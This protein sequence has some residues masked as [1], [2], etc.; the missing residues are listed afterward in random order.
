MEPKAKIH[1]VSLGVMVF[2]GFCA[3]GA[4]FP[5]KTTLATS[6]RPFSG[7]MIEK[8]AD[9]GQL[10][11]AFEPNQG[12]TDPQVQ[13]LA[14]GRGYSLFLTS[15]EAVLE[16]NPSHP[17]PSFPAFF[18][19]GSKGFKP[20]ASLFSTTR[21]GSPTVLRMKLEGAQAQNLF[22]STESLPGTSNYFIGKDPSRWHRNIPQYGKVQASGVYPGVDLV[23]YGNQGHLEYDFVVKPGGDPK[24]IHLQYEGAKSSRVNAQGDLELDTNQGTLLFR[25]PAMYQESQGQR[26]TVEG[27]YHLDGNGRLGFDVKGYDATQPLVIDPVLDYST[28]WGGSG[29]DQGVAIALDSS[30]NAYITG[31]T[32]SPDFPTVNA[33]QGA[34][35]GTEN[36]F[37]AEINPS[38]TAMLYSTYL[39][40]NGYDSGNGIG[41]DSAGNA[42][43]TGYTSSTNFPLSNPL[44]P[45]LAGSY[46]VFVAE[47][48]T[49]GAG[50]AYSTYIGGS[51]M[52][53]GFGLAIDGSDDAYVVGQTSS[54]NFPTQ[55]PIQPTLTAGANAF[56]LK[57]NPTG[58]ALAYSTYLGG[59]T[60]E[61]GTAI[62]VDSAGNAY[63][64][65]DTASTDFPTQNP[66]QATL[67][68]NLN[69]FITE[70]NAS[71]T[72]LVYSTYLGG[73]NTDFSQGIA[74]D[75][76][77]N[78]YISGTTNSTNFPLQNPIQPA[79]SNTNDN[80]F[81][82]EIGA[83]GTSLVY[84]TYLGGGGNA[85][86]YGDYA[87]F[88][89]GSGAYVGNTIA[90][91]NQGYAYV[92][93]ATGSPD[94]PIVN[95]PQATNNSPYATAFV[96]QINLNGAGLIYST[97]L[98]G[99]TFESGYGIATDNNGNAYVV[100]QTGS[101]DFP[102]T[103][104]PPQSAL[105][106]TANAFIAE[107][108]DPLPPTPTLTPTSTPTFTPSDTPTITPT[109][110]PTATPTL[111]PTGTATSTFTVTP[112]L[113][114]TMTFTPT[115]TITSTATATP[116]ATPF[117]VTV[118]VGDPY[119]NPI[120]GSGLLQIPLTVPTG[121]VAHWT[122]YTAGFRKVYENSRPVSGNYDKL[123]WDLRDTWGTTVAN[124]LYYIRIQVSGLTAGSRTVKVLVIR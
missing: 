114:A 49:G 121:S 85:N 80:V 110:T 68:G 84:S 100:G 92:T 58:S 3:L 97:F 99:S 55:N 67:G 90:V 94:F 39:G 107:I 21:S 25:A 93:G 26:K 95:A 47:I 73:S 54:P 122:V 36:A 105:A 42:F 65:G 123:S 52:D 74:V 28:Y 9:Y 62:A 33:G 18:S 46:N 5:K 69:P 87:G 43:I 2:L 70:I 60:Y 31:N 116:T 22:Q 51:G 103:V 75:P 113:T 56:V 115:P 32:Q 71:G 96:A 48:T 104:T 35:A 6:H 119:P 4:G 102:V 111:T 57:L 40:G 8:R 120:S 79:L 16:L 34:L 44:Q 89:G 78:A 15:Q 14:H 124:G 77:S 81:V 7:R 59:S 88:E 98:G 20:K 23:Y 118:T 29:V 10:P 17:A 64:T 41:V 117:I 86:G 27:Q 109:S 53:G 112:S 30:G 106:G 82:S 108:S 63:A 19:K 61:F 24:S 83:G 50:L 91:D 38:G 37:V 12:Q 66:I 76:S 101:A 45:N 1:H 13:Y 72:A 11:L